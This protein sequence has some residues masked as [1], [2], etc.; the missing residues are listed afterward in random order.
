[1]PA[2]SEMLRGVLAK[3]YVECPAMRGIAATDAISR[4]I[5]PSARV[6]LWLVQMLLPDLVA[7]I[8]RMIVEQSDNHP[9][10][11]LLGGLLTY[12]YNPLDLIG[13]DTPLGRVDDTIIC[14]LGLLR[15]AELEHVELDP[16][17]RAMSEYAA[18]AL[19]SLTEDLQDAIRAFVRDLEVSTRSAKSLQA[20]P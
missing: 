20:Y 1:M 18:S 15:G 10:R 8:E 11:R 9:L 5:K 17:V 7:A 16:D 13:D 3:E 4:T 2:M 12:V 6:Q 19:P 14:A